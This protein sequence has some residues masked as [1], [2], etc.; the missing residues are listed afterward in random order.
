MISCIIR[1]HE[2]VNLLSVKNPHILRSLFEKNNMCNNSIKYWAGDL[3]DT[4]RRRREDGV[5][6]QLE[7]ECQNDDLS[8]IS[9]IV[10]RCRRRRF[11]WQHWQVCRGKD[12]FSDGMFKLSLSSPAINWSFSSL[13]RQWAKMDVTFR[14]HS[15]DLQFNFVFPFSIFGF[16][17]LRL[18]KLSTKKLS[19]Y[20]P[21]LSVDFCF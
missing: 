3:H 10:S 13:R 8:D 4:I 14:L 2:F 6:D 7:R 17:S 19:S 11:W 12:H 18:K 5:C 20:I 1:F 21:H 15:I 9:R 16:R